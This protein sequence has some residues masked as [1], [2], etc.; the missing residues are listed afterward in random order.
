MISAKVNHEWIETY[1]SLF[2]LLN[3]DDTRHFFMFDL[4]NKIDYNKY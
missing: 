4:M 3:F 1:P 2:T